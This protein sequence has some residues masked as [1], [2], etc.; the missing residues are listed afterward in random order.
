MTQVQ[1]IALTLAGLFALSR[2]EA[3]PGNNQEWGPSYLNLPGY[4]RGM[5]N[6]NPG[7]IKIGS[8]QWV[9]KIPV[10]QNTDGTFEQFYGYLYGLR[11]MIKLLRD[12]YMRRWNLRTIREILTVYAPE[13]ENPTSSYIN[14]VSRSTGIAPDD[15]L[16]DDYAT[17]QKLVIAMAEVEN[18]RPAV[19]STQ[20]SQAWNLL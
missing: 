11:A 7:N 13:I 5:R 4:P 18:G 8:S 2:L 1:R 15:R 20:F 6:N 9:G 19:T 17:L 3:R 12:T 10:S 16:A 14:M